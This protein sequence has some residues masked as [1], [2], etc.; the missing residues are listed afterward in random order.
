MTP[1]VNPIGISSHLDLLSQSDVVR[2]LDL[3]QAAG[4]YWIRLEFKWNALEPSLG[5]W[6]F[7]NYDFIVSNILSRGMSIMGLLAQY[8][9]PSWYSTPQN[10][11]P[12]PADYANW[13]SQVASRYASQ[14][15]L[16]ELGNEPNESLFWY[17]S[18]NATAYTALLQAGYNAIKAV[19]PSSK[20]ISAGLS[21]N[22]PGAFLESMYSADAKGYFDYLGMHPYNQPNAPDFRVLDGMLGHM[23]NHGDNKQIIITEVGWPTYSG[24]SGVSEA[25]QATYIGQVYQMIMHGNYQYIPIACIYDFLDDGTDPNNAEDHFGLLRT[26]YSQKPAYSTMQTER[27][28]YNA[29]FTP[30][31]P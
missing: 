31:N 28:D 6:N 20:V 16:W 21:Q 7:G 19:N 26:D 12:A 2:Q 22:S 14:I 8:Q 1:R 27:A 3:M 9:V 24:S 10:R 25:N 13:I 18:P 17:P 5:T 4:V 15:S 29:N 11:P 30:I 23:S